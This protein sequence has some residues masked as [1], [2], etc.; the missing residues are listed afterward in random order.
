MITGSGEHGGAISLD[1]IRR[2][3]EFAD[4]AEIG[5]LSPEDLKALPDRAELALYAASARIHLIG[6]DRVARRLVKLAKEWGCD[7]RTMASVLVSSIYESLGRAAGVSGDEDRALSAFEKAIAIGAPGSDAELLARARL[8][9][10]KDWLGHRPEAACNAR[11]GLDVDAEVFHESIPFLLLDSKSLPRSGLH[12]LKEALARLL[13]TRLSFCERYQVPECCGTFPCTLIG[14]DVDDARN[15][16]V[17]RLRLTKSHDFRL[18]DP[19]YKCTRNLRQIVLVR[20]PLFILTSWFALEQLN[21]YQDE[22]QRQEISH[23]EILLTHKRSLLD[24]AYRILD[25]HFR[26]P[27]PDDVMKWI[28]DKSRYIVGFNSKWIAL[29]DERSEAA[30]HVVQ[31]DQIDKFIV[32]LLDEYREH[33]SVEARAAFDGF[34]THASNDF[35]MR[36]NPFDV[37]SRAVSDC[38]VKYAHLFRKGAAGIMDADRSGYMKK[39]YEQ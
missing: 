39:Y 34:R 26:E 14:S 15:D 27:D 18:T 21:L 23:Q 4:W 29:P 31:Y 9:T 30:P 10:N 3:W 16:R 35:R 32:E 6:T 37:Q 7:S 12:Y 11:Q 25:E 17:F 13:G 24:A 36:S 28:I 22:L 5:L 33:L 8:D 19:V 1:R 2:Q 38:L 20:D